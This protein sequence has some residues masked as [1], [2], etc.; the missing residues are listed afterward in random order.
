MMGWQVLPFQ[1]FTMFTIRKLLS[2]TLLQRRSFD[3]G[4]ISWYWSNSKKTSSQTTWHCFSFYPYMSI[5]N[6]VSKNVTNSGL[7]KAHNHA[8]LAEVTIF[9]MQTDTTLRVNNGS[10]NENCIFNRWYLSTSRKTMATSAKNA[11]RGL[12]WCRIDI[13]TRPNNSIQDSLQIHNYELTACNYLV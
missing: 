2:I 9:C 11:W 1:S 12:F 4:G 7:D 13:T 5:T 6:R 8:L 3:I 10:G